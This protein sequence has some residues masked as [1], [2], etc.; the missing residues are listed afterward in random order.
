MEC[1]LC[2]KTSKDFEIEFET[3]EELEELR[4]SL[5]AM[6]RYAKVCESDGE[7]PVLLYKIKSKK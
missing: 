4:N 5:T 2:G 6:L 3:I 1:K 7:K